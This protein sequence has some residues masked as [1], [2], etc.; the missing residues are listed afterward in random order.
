M[1]WNYYPQCLRARNATASPASALPARPL[2]RRLVG[3]LSGPA[4]RHN[5][6]DLLS[7]MVPDAG[8]RIESEGDLPSLLYH[9]RAV[10]PVEPAGVE[11]VG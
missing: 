1:Q 8:F 2:V 4:M 9:L 5:P 7:T 10:R 6:R 11:P 3:V